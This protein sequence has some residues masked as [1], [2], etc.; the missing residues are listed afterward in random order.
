VSRPPESD[1]PGIPAVPPDDAAPDIEFSFEPAD[2]GSRLDVAVTR[3]Q[4]QFSRNFIRHLVNDGAILINGKIAKPSYKVRG[5]ERVSIEVPEPE[6]IEARPEDISLSVIFEDSDIIAINKPP[7]M[8][9]HPSSGH[10]S[11]SLVNGLLFHCKDLSSINGSLRPGIV[12][13]LDKDTSGVIVAAKNDAAHRGLA[14]Q[15]AGRTVR[16]EYAALCHGKPLLEKFFNAGRIGRHPVRRTEMAVMRGEG[17]G[18]EAH[19]DFE[20]VERFPQA[21]VFFVRALPKTGRTHQIRVHLSHLGFPILCDLLYGRETALPDL[22]LTRHAL[23]AQR[24]LITHPLTRKS[25]TLEAQ[26]P[27]DMSTAL[28]TLRAS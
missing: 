14:E 7:G 23:H 24:L 28:S 2:A 20:V 26:I 15:F 17:D 19:T 16:K 21:G 27:D 10:T 4:P 25:L 13:R 12:H 8:V 1:S 3:T 9:A 18:R 22:G 6:V 11:G 5:T